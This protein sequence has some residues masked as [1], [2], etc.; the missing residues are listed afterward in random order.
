M[1]PA[2]VSL[3]LRGSVAMSG[4]RTRLAWALCAMA[5]CG[6]CR[7]ARHR[8]GSTTRATRSCRSLVPISFVV[9]VAASRCVGALIAVAAAGQPVGW[10]L[11]AIGLA[12][13][14]RRVVERPSQLAASPTGTRSPP[15]ASA[16]WRG[17]RAGSGCRRI[18]L[19]PP[20]SRCCSR[21]GGCSRRGGAGRAGGRRCRSPSVVGIAVAPG[22]WTTPR[23]RTSVRAGAVERRR[24]AGWLL[25]VILAASRA[26]ASLVV[27]FRRSRGDRS[28]SSSSGV[29]CAAALVLVVTLPLPMPLDAGEHERRASSTRSSASLAVRGRAIAIAMLRYRLYDIDVVINRTLVYGALTAT[30]AGA[31]LGSVLLLQLVLS[32]LTGLGPR[33]RR[34]PRW[35]SRRFP[36]RPRPHPG[37]VDRRFYRRRYDAARTLERFAA[38]LRDE[39]DLEALERRA[40][41]RRRARRCSRRTCRCGCG[42]GRGDGARRARVGDGHGRS[43]STSAASRRSPTGRRRARRWTYLNEFFER[44]RARRSSA[45]R[46]R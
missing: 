6:R 41:R 7:R 24:S 12:L 42:R 43:S 19:A 17:F 26:V 9:A 2:H 10:L 23:S 46:H 3:W 16:T 15:T 13:R 28:A 8:R 21:T 5:R 39:V 44:R 29:S 1:Q 22:R 35:R 25:L 37:A 18:G 14:D 36:A 27:R 45:R 34:R 20:C 40:A 33:G 32:G 31:Y 4:R 38:R 30:L 11:C